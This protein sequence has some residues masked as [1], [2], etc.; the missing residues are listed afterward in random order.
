M[1]DNVW[2]GRY[3]P[4]AAAAAAAAAAAVR[5]RFL[6]LLFCFGNKNLPKEE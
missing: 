4:V 6:S 5:T 1:G 2:T 3:P